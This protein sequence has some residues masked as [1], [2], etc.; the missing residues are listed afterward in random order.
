[1]LLAVRR[2]LS[3][4]PEG[5]HRRSL[6]PRERHADERESDDFSADEGQVRERRE[7]ETCDGAAEEQDQPPPADRHAHLPPPRGG[8]LCGATAWRQAGRFRF[9]RTAFDLPLFDGSVRG[10]PAAQTFCT[11]PWMERRSW[12]GKENSY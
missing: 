12:R 7:E 2:S 11:A 6:E 5:G 8:V 1:M 9:Q 10:L 3:R 4:P